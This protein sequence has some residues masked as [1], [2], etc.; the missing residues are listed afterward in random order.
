MQ[1]L[2]G[3][4]SLSLRNLFSWIQELSLCIV[5]ISDLQIGE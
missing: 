4:E 5:G 2:P 3:F 1:V